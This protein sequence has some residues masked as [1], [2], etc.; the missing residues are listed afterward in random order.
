L[1]FLYTFSC[2]AAYKLPGNEDAKAAAIEAAEQLII[3]FKPKGEFIQA[4]GPLDDPA[5]YRLI[6]DCL[7]NL[8]LLF[9]ATEATGDGKYRAIAEKHLKTALSVVI[10][11]DGTTHHTF[12]FNPETGAPEKGVTHQGNSDDSCWARGQAWGVYGTA[13]A[14]A[15]TKDENVLK[16]FEILTDKFIELLPEDNVPYWDMVFTDGSNEPR[17]TS[18]A[19]IAVC[20]ILQMNKFINN[21][22]YYEAAVKMLESLI[23]NYLTAGYSNGLLSDAM[24]SKPGGHN[25]ECNI[26]GDYYFMEALARMKNPDWKMYW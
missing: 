26:W 14:Y 2:V 7:L 16:C 11:E 25:P 3:R 6:I 23:D 20:G 8:P 19:A 15:Y 5:N 10:R 1:G 12:Y 17:D 24:Y 13:L 22:K 9:W 18:A 4:W 21:E